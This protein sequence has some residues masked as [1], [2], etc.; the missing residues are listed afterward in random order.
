M[1]PTEIA[2]PTK[3][4][5]ARQPNTPR[6]FNPCHVISSVCQLG[7]GFGYLS[8]PVLEHGTESALELVKRF[9]ERSGQHSRIHSRRRVRVCCP[10]RSMRDGVI[11]FAR[12][13]T[14]PLRDC[15]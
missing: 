13:V 15:I 9:S 4:G 5:T 14:N 7:Y 6:V 1:F 12:G 10:L 8:L 11:S 3:T 2:I